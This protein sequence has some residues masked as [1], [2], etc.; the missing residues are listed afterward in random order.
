VNILFVNNFRGRG[1]GEEFLRD[2]LP[3]LVRKGVHVGLICRPGTPLSAMFDH[4][5]IALYPIARDGLDGLASIF[6]TARVISNRPY[7]IVAIHRGHDVVQSWTG[8]LLSGLRPLLIYTPQVPEFIHSRFLLSRMHRIVTISRYI[9]DKIVRF[10][11]ASAQTTSIIYYGI[12]LVKFTSISTAKNVFRKRFGLAPETR[13][14]GT[15]GD[16]WKNQIEFLDTLAIIKKSF[17]DVKFALVASDRGIG[18]ID[19]FKKH[20]VALGL[21]GDILWA[22]RLSKDEMLSFYADIDIAVSTHRNEGF[23]IW[24]LEALAMGKPVVAFDEGGIRDSL[25]NCPGGVLVRG[26]AREMADEI[27]AILGDDTRRNRMSSGGKNWVIDRFSRERM[28]DDYY[29]F[30]SEALVAK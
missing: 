21:T 8:A 2:L 18:Q 23:G 3:G 10:H 29:R 12:D 20:A 5:A 15:V 30:F 6:K 1:G 17:P 14:L 22:G 28:V 26:G 7:D 16:L 25:E 9:R 11:P 27:M 13:I 4:D 19:E 24:I